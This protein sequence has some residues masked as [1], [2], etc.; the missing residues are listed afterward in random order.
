[1]YT[2]TRTVRTWLGGYDVTDRLAHGGWLEEGSPQRW[3]QVR[4]S[5]LNFVTVRS[6]I[7]SRR[8]AFRNALEHVCPCFQ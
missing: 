8:G 6:N 5:A 1:M 4:P 7:R 3:G 2:G